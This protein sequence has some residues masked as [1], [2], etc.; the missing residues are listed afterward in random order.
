MKRSDWT[1]KMLDKLRTMRESG[2]GFP[3]IARELGVTTH[4]CKLTCCI[5]GI[6]LNG[7]VPKGDRRPYTVMPQYRSKPRPIMDL[8]GDRP[9]ISCRKIFKSW[10][11]TKNQ[12]CPRCSKNMNEY[13][14]N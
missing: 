9:C 8:S 4:Q 12:I 10:D 11:R 1:E 7:K 2:I 3:E 13:S 5:E 6:Y 14:A